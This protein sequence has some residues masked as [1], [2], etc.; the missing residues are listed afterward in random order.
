M[1]REEFKSRVED[2]TSVFDGMKDDL[3]VA[4]ERSYSLIFVL[5]RCVG[6]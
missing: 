5:E 4:R 3:V 1:Q 6:F 2:I